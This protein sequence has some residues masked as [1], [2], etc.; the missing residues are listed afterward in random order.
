MWP[1]KEMWR[2]RK[3]FDTDSAPKCL[4]WQ[5]TVDG[6]AIGGGI[7]RI[8][9]YS[10]PEIAEEMRQACLRAVESFNTRLEEVC[11][12]NMI[13]RVLVDTSRDMG[14]LF[15]DYLNQRSLLNRGR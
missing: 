3:D 1:G 6:A 8:N 10:S 5:P 2:E 14:E 15:V 7:R 13:E 12:R 9:P 11:T 4:D